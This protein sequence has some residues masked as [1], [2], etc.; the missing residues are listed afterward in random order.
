MMFCAGIETLIKTVI[1]AYFFYNKNVF[2]FMK[3]KHSRQCVGYSPGWVGT[4]IPQVPL[5]MQDA[6]M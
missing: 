5:T 6:H 3:K 4:S 1:N 2:I